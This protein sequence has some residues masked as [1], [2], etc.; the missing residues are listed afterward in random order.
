MTP[1]II[2]RFVLLQEQVRTKDGLVGFGLRV[3][4]IMHTSRDSKKEKKYLKLYFLF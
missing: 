4:F 2:L 1:L 3:T